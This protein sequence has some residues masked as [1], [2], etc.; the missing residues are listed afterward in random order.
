[1]RYDLSL[2][3]V[4]IMLAFFRCLNAALASPSPSLP[5]NNS[6]SS[7]LSTIPGKSK[8]SSQ[9]NLLA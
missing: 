2:L 4:L 1:M 6:V 9:A 5:L 3:S 7:F 8:N